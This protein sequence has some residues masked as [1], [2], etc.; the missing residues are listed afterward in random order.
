M[1]F[2]FVNRLELVGAG[3]RLASGRFGGETS[4]VLGPEDLVRDRVDRVADV[5]HRHGEAL[6][7]GPQLLDLGVERLA[8]PGQVGEHPGA[9]GLGLLDHLA[10]LVAG[11]VEERLRLGARRGEGV[12]RVRLGPVPQLG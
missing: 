9:Q 8:P 3:C 6:P 10:A 12:G 11:P 1:R 5:A 2:S 4:L 7:A